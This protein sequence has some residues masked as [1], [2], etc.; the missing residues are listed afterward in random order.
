MKKVAILLLAYLTMVN[1][2]VPGK[3]TYAASASVAFS[4]DSKKK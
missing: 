4:A 1:I 3:A 2:L